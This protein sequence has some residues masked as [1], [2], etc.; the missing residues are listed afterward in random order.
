MNPVLPPLA[1]RTVQR[2]IRAFAPE[3]IVLFGSHAK[4]TTHPGSDVDLLVITH[5][6]GDVTAYQQRARQLA[7]DA[8]P[9]LDFVFATPE[10][11]AGAA[12]APNKFLQSVLETGIVIYRHEPGRRLG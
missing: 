4:G 8:F 9:P 3:Q 10:E 6:G 5:V 1:Q 11:V 12:S 7:A 2:L